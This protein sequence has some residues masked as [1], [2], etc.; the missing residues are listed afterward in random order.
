VLTSG[1][2]NLDFTDAGNDTCISGSSF[3]VNATCTV[4]VSFAPRFSGP[5]YGAVVL[6]DANGVVATGYL[7]G[8]GS[9]PQLNFLPAVQSNLG[10]GLNGPIG[11]AVDGA[12]DVFLTDR[13]RIVEE[14]YSGS[15]YTQS[16]I[17]T[18]GLKVAE[19]IAIDSAGNLYVADAEGR[20]VLKLTPSGGSYTQQAVVSNLVEPTGVAVDSSG[21]VY[22]T[23]YEAGRLLKETPTPNGY[24]ES[25]IGSGFGDLSVFGV[26]VD[27][28][29]NLYLAGEGVLYIETLTA[30]Q[31]IQSFV[32]APVSQASGIAVDRNGDLYI[33]ELNNNQVVQL[34]FT[35]QGRFQEKVWGSVKS[36]RGLAFDGAGN[37]YVASAPNGPPYAVVKL[38]SADA[39]A[40]NFG[41]VPYGNTGSATL[42]T[43]TLENIG[44]AALQFPALESTANP[45]LAG[46][47]L[48]GPGS[49]SG[50]AVVA[51]GSAT[52]GTLAAGFDCELLVRF[53]VS[54]LGPQSGSIVFTD[55]NLNASGPAY[56]TQTLEL[57]G[58]LVQA[59]QIVTFTG[60]PSSLRYGQ[61]PIKLNV[62]GGGSGNPVTFSVKGPGV[63]KGDSIKVT[64]AGTITVT[65][66]QAD[67]ADYLPAPT[68]VLSIIIEKAS[69]AIA[70]KNTE[71]LYGQANPAFKY[72]LSGLVNGD[73]AA[74]ALHGSPDLTTAATKIS[75]P[76]KYPITT[77]IGTLSSEDYK[78]DLINATLTV[79]TLGP[80]AK[81]KITP[82][83][84]KYTDSVTVTMTDATPDAE[85]H[86]TTNADEPTAG[87]PK[88]TKAIKLTSGAT[89]K[90][91]AIATG[92]TKSAVASESYSITK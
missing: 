86:Y 81:P 56:A 49:V 40:V 23:D 22:I 71:R 69:L 78:L 8:I 50:C 76:G 53:D 90:A 42:K 54:T 37:L 67:N 1:V 31:Y 10:T 39:P 38:D 62:T 48:L 2:A 27:D 14:I 28:A 17:S 82:P 35:T 24:S 80:A 91:I 29:G 68:V 15:S 72:S 79:E 61:G 75:L 83:A 34:S 46:E 65:A 4:N 32:K 87:S 60:F 57:T 25:I 5:R 19:G 47:F 74:E 43:I 36:P 89:V 3:D 26:A 20:D 73:T 16:V 88:Y 30:G 66:K 59:T 84:G 44:N 58:S 63:L 6:N 92:Y 55:S 18:T 52:P 21:N 77:R 85:I 64:G 70:A 45:A 13:T 51:S 41:K 33:S 11:V 9:G 12:G 7:E